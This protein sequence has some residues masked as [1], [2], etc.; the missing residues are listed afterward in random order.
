MPG[1]CEAKTCFSYEKLK[2]K[3]KTK[4]G[5]LYG[6]I[7]NMALYRLEM[8]NVSRANGV[9]SVAKAAYRHRSLW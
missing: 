8:Q 2:P 1:L 6:G 3:P 9:S 4:I 5:V 7:I